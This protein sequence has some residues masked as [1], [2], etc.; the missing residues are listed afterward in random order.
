[1]AEESVGQ[2]FSGKNKGNLNDILRFRTHLETVIKSQ[3]AYPD[4]VFSLA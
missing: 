2:G 4:G 3:A 1:M